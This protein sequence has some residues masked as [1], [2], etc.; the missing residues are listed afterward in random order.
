MHRQIGTQ[1]KICYMKM[2][3]AGGLPAFHTI[4]YGRRFRSIIDGHGGIDKRYARGM[5]AVS[6]RPAAA[7]LS[8]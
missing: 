6:G 2:I 8:R 7:V 5:A 1:Y 4:R 3:G